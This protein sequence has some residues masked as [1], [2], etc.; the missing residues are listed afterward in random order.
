MANYWQTT[1]SMWYGTWEIR[2]SRMKLGSAN[3]SITLRPSPPYRDRIKTFQK[4]NAIQ[5]QIPV[6]DRGLAS[7]QICQCQTNGSPTHMHSL[8]R[9]DQ[10]KIYH[11]FNLLA[12]LFLGTSVLTYQVRNVL[13]LVRPSRSLHFIFSLIECGTT[14]LCVC[15]ADS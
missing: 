13:D 11:L 6:G 3:T 10:V 2:R 15:T 14:T 4:L 12:G 1:G 7:F 8:G 5:I 9:L